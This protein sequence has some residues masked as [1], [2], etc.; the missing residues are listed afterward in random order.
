MTALK[1][2]LFQFYYA[3]SNPTA[4]E[5]L[6]KNTLDTLSNLNTIALYNNIG[7][8][9]WIMVISLLCYYISNKLSNT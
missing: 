4:Y 6:N 2:W 5:R 3:I 1:G 8:W 9:L 7:L